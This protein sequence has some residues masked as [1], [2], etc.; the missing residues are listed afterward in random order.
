[1]DSVDL[2]IDN[3]ELQDLLALFHVPED[4]DENDLKQA[5]QIVLKTHPDKS[6]LD[7]KYFLFFSKAYKT[8]YAI[9]NFKNKS[10]KKSES[11]YGC[12]KYEEGNAILETFFENHKQLQQPK[13]FNKW[14]N[15][16]FEKTRVANESDAKGYGDWLKSDEDIE[17]DTAEKMS[18]NAMHEAFVQKKR[19]LRA[20]VPHHEIPDWHAT[21]MNYSHL[22]GD[23]PEEYS[24]GIFS[25]LSFQDVRKAHKES[26]IPV[27]E[28]DF[29]NVHKFKNL[30][31]IVQHRTQQEVQVKPLSES[32][33][34]H[35]LKSRE[36]MDNV[37]SSHRAFKLAKQLEEATS[38][39]NEFWSKLKT[40][41]NDG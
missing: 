32:Q 22:G 33:A 3:Y 19:A 26:I 2:N 14:F 23:A 30:D 10:M 28:E 17:K 15:E 24:S 18:E 37:E 35:Y 5:K 8:L 41:K 40:I 34:L 31:D 20:L 21:H 1:M 27:T 12:M 13:A 7:P 6:K 38:K 39:S 29:H 16:Q 9:Y 4:F 25:Q 11:D 36:S